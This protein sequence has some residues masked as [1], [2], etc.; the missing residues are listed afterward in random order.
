MGF[1]NEPQLFF[2]EILQVIEIIS[3][4]FAIRRGETFWRCV[5][6][7]SGVVVKPQGEREDLVSVERC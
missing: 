2:A 6:V 5:I 4:L 1:E 7:Q 3:E